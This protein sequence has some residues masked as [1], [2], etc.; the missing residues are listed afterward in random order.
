MI[1]S[2]VHARPLER[3]CTSQTMPGA[4]CAPA[5]FCTHCGEDT[6]TL[7]HQLRGGQ[8]QNLC[9][10]CRTCRKGKPFISPRVVEAFLHAARQ[11]D[12]HETYYA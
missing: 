12:R 7:Y 6:M 3:P 9:R 1:A 5:A 2:P 11:E 4:A 8:W 10:V